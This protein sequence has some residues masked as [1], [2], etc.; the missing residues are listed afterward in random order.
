MFVAEK[1]AL[2]SMVVSKT[3]LRHSVITTFFFTF[4][5]QGTFFVTVL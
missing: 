1:K 4:F 2:L 3:K 5:Y